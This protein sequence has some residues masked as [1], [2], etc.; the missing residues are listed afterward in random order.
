MR[1][2]DAD[3]L[4]RQHRQT[5]ETR[6]R[7]F[8]FSMNTLFQLMTAAALCL[9][10]LA[11]VFSSRIPYFAEVNM[12]DGTVAIIWWYWDEQRRGVWRP[13]QP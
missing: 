11:S 10:T 3:M 13:W 12:D 1:K 4:S 5:D 6:P 9:A 7:R 8:R 2:S